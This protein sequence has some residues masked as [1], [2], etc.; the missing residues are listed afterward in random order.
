MESNTII[1]FP[2]F[3]YT[4]EVIFT[5]DLNDSR[6]KRS[7]KL[8]ALPSP[9]GKTVDGLHCYNE[10]YP[11]SVIF[12]L[13]TTTVGVIAHEIYHF[14]RRMFRWIDA[15]PEEEVIAYHLTYVLDKVIDFKNSL[16]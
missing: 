5:D 14:I 4:L 3:D 2:I 7:D 15:Q 8:G 12:L 16:K 9:I 13:N 11:E 1:E 10:Q 6:E